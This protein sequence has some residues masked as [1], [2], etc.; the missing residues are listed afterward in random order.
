MMGADAPIPPVTMDA[1]APDGAPPRRF[2]DYV[3]KI[4]KPHYL[5]QP[6]AMMW[7]YLFWGHRYQRPVPCGTG[8]AR[9]MRS[10][11]PN[12]PATEYKT[13]FPVLQ[14][15]PSLRCGGSALDAFR[16]GVDDHLAAP[17]KPDHGKAGIFCGFNSERGG[18]PA[19]D[20]D[21]DIRD[22]ALAHHLG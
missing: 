21:R 22:Q 13:G 9:G 20:N 2:S 14:N 10:N 15:Q 8:G 3:I 11:L 1:A 17:R 16:V 5:K 12:I 6:H 18:C 4:D 19:G 7:S